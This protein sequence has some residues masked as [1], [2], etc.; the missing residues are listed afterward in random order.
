MFPLKIRSINS[1]ERTSDFLGSHHA[2]IINAEIVFSSSVRVILCVSV[3]SS[4]RVIL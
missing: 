2:E 4:V 1:K 3:S